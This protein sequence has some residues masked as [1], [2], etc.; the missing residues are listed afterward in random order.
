MFFRNSAH[1]TP[2]RYDKIILVGYQAG[3]Y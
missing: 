2:V 1:S 3:F